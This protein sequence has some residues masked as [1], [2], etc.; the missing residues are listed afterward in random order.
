MLFFPCDRREFTKK[1]KMDATL[2]GGKYHGP[3]ARRTSLKSK[4]KEGIQ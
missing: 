2:L 4:A 1:Q 3:T